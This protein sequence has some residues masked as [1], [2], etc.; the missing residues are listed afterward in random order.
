MP[1]LG[2]GPRPPDS[3]TLGRSP[4]QCVLICPGGDSGARSS[5]R[6]PDRD[7]THPHSDDLP[8]S[9]DHGLTTAGESHV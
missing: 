8:A 1:M 6:P 2:S 9:A 5:V 4:Q 3:E 7:V